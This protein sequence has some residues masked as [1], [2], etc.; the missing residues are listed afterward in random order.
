MRRIVAGYRER[1]LPLDAVHLD[2]DHL[3]A[4]Q[5]FTVDQETYPGL[6]RLAED[7]RRDGVRL[8]SIVDPAIKAEAGNAVYDAG[9]SADAFVKDAGEAGARRG[10]AG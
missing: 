9:A 8:V 5:V 1:G 10:V 4:F 2:I 7:L 6:P 3:D